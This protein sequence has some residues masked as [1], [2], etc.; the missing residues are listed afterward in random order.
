MG[1]N[2]KKDTTWP[3]VL[4]I[5]YVPFID[6]ATAAF[7]NAQMTF[8]LESPDHFAIPRDKIG[9][10]N[11]IILFAV[12]FSSLVLMPYNGYIYE[13]FGRK[14]PLTLCPFAIA[15][16]IWMLP[17]T[18]PSFAWLCF[19]RS[20]TSYFNGFLVTSPLIADYI[21]SDSRG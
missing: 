17:Q 5:F 8:L 3:N 11:S 18:S 13:I 16:F 7:Y 4:A 20:A 1:L 2:V 19:V 10:A 6:S 15:L 9:R 21:K 12:Y 14:G